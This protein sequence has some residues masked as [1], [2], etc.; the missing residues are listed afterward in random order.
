MLL[1]HKW[2]GVTSHDAIVAKVKHPLSSSLVVNWQD[3]ETGGAKFSLP[4]YAWKNWMKRSC[5]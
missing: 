2:F 3:A 1:R 5:T 4:R